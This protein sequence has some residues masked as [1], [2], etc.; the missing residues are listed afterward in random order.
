MAHLETEE[1]AVSR[2]A[3]ILGIAGVAAGVAGGLTG[4]IVQGRRE[5]T[6]QERLRLATDDLT[7]SSGAR[8]VLSTVGQ[9]LEEA[10]ASAQ[11]DFETALKKRK[12]RRN[13]LGRKRSS[14][15]LG[16]HMKKT[17]LENAERFGENLHD[18]V[19]KSTQSLN[20]Y[21]EE[22]SDV[23]TKKNR[24]KLR[25]KVEQ[26]QKEL[27]ALAAEGI[28]EI[29]SK[30]NRE[31]IRKAVEQG[32][33]E[34]SARAN[35]G[36]SDLMK[37]RKEATNTSQERLHVLESRAR[38]LESKARN[39]LDK[40]LKPTLEKAAESAWA[41][42]IEARKRL[43]EEAEDLEKRYAKAKP[44]IDKSTERY[45]QRA[46]ELREE[47]L[48]AAEQRAH[49]AEKTL[50]GST[51]HALQMAQGA[52]TSAKEGGKNFGSLLLWLAIAGGV[53]YAFLLDEE[54]KRKARE[55]AGSAYH[56]GRAIY[57]DVRGQNA[58]FNGGQT[59]TTNTTDA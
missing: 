14:P 12:K 58:D 7:A 13:R 2:A 56:E 57:E 22:L 30:K 34:L 39:T 10:K 31:K 52:G 25:K 21:V 27:T 59:G 48:H 42:A 28:S 20:E 29:N 46:A 24:E 50:Q 8:S 23:N 19:D 4:M 26:G 55:L 45:M 53:V 3:R 47:L 9:S 33:K 6:A 5:P 54:K 40:T 37:L 43:E 11:A 38:E 36:R 51:E 16:E 44:K 17:L 32:Q 49:E 41:G 18:A 35:E 15:S 1:T